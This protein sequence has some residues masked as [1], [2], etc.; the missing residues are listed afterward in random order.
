MLSN[1][2]SQKFYCKYFFYVEEIH[3]SQPK[4]LVWAI[5]AIK[6]VLQ[7]FLNNEYNARREVDLSDIL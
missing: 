4:G 1:L 2:T 5:Y 6:I 3:A 7:V